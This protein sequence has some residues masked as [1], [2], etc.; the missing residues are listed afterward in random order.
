MVLQR[1]RGPA[2][3]CFGAWNWVITKSFGLKEAP[4]LSLQMRRSLQ[5]R[6]QSLCPRE[7]A[8]KRTSLCSYLPRDPRC[9]LVIAETQ[10]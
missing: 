10:Q 1:R 7:P 8:Q 4:G 3:G 2:L 5:D 6:P 9:Q